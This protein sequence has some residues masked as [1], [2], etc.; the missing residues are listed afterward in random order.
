MVET[1]GPIGEVTDLGVD[2]LVERERRYWFAWFGGKTGQRLA[3]ISA[4]L[5]RRLRAYRQGRTGRPRV[6]SPRLFMGEGRRPGGDYEGLPRVG[7]YHAVRD[8]AERS[9]LERARI[10]PD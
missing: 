6:R 8:A 10:H 5:Y 9:D 7:I 4:E 2:D 1:A 3:P